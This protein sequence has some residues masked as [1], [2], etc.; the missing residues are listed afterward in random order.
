MYA[1]LK[2]THRKTIMRSISLLFVIIF[3][4]ADQ[5][6]EAQSFRERIKERIKERIIKKQEEKPAPKSDRDNE[7]KI[8]EPGD[9]TKSFVHNGLTRMYK[10][11]VPKSYNSEYPTPVLFVFHG[12]GGD[13]GFQSTEKYYKQISKSE[14]SGVIAIFPNGYSKFQSGKFATWN[15]GKCCGDARN[16]NVDDV[17]FIKELIQKVS[18]QLNIDKNR[19]FATGMSN[20]G[21]LSYRLACELSGLFKGVAAVAGTDNTLECIPKNPISILHIHAQDDDNVLFFGGHGN[22]VKDKTKVTKFNSVPA[23]ISKWIKLNGCHEK[24]KRILE[25][26]GAYCDKYLSCKNNTEV[27]L[28]VTEKGGHS[29]PGGEKVMGGGKTSKAISA[30]DI[31]WD[32][33]KNK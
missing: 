20:G 3:L 25:K 5:F 24:P 14:E 1:D 17:D 29:W 6:A 4:V 10:I 18:S 21:M 15:A 31:I 13:M 12:G 32:F 8:T 30:N 27:Q 23:T 9:Y 2:K 16:K 33:F 28:C 26:S 19:V 22:G 11:H 7:S